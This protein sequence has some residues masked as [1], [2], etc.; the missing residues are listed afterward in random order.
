MDS[1]KAESDE[2]LLRMSL[3]GLKEL[4]QRLQQRNAHLQDVHILPGLSSRID[5]IFW[6]L[7][8]IGLSDYSSDSE[9]SADDGD[10]KQDGRKEQAVEV[11]GESCFF[12]IE[13]N[14]HESSRIPSNIQLSSPANGSPLINAPEVDEPDLQCQNAVT[15]IEESVMSSLR[16]D[17]IETTLKQTTPEAVHSLKK[18]FL[19]HMPLGYNGALEEL[20]KKW[21]A[22]EKECTDLR[23]QTQCSDLQRKLEESR[24]QCAQQQVTVEEKWRVEKEYTDLQT[25]CCDLQRKLE[26]S[27]GQS[28][29]KQVTIEEMTRRIGVLEDE[30][31]PQLTKTT[32][33]NTAKPCV[34]IR[35]WVPDIPDS[36]GPSGGEQCVG[37]L[38]VI[39]LTLDQPDDD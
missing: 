30:H 3:Q 17:E 23:I 6:K 35:P 22:K 33:E 26:E 36:D 34:V 19:S 15:E 12:S 4:Q 18:P 24:G 16:T 38:N 10:G 2:E 39:A 28:A 7:A 37:A 5:T 14:S 11:A 29:E 13:D 32:Q 21:R 20:Q 31:R 8:L 25:Q 1:A 9:D 27:K